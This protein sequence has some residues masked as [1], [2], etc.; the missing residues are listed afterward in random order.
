MCLPKK[1]RSLKGHI[2]D[3]ICKYFDKNSLCDYVL[4]KDLMEWMVNQDGKLRDKFEKR[5]T[6]VVTT[7][8]EFADAK[9]WRKKLAQHAVGGFLKLLRNHGCLD[10]VPNEKVFLTVIAHLYFYIGIL[11]LDRAAMIGKL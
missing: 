7:V 9:N 8:E 2:H 4:D 10:D 11:C 6:D 1:K 3:E 5:F